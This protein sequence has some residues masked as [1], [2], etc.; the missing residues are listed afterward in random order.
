MTLVIF[1]GGIFLGFI[2]GF[3]VMALLAMASIP[4]KPKWHTQYGV[5]V[6]VTP[7]SPASLSLRW[8]TGHRASE[9]HY[10]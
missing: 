1:C 8:R 7:P 2:L 6:P 9:I 4:S 3:V 5:S 10:S